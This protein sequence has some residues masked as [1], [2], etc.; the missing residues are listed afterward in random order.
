MRWQNYQLDNIVLKATEDMTLWQSEIGTIKI[1]KNTLALQIRLDDQKGGYLFCGSGKL[2][3]DTIVETEEG[4]FGRPV[5]KEI[6]KPFLMLGETEKIQWNLTE[7]K[8]GDSAETVVENQQ[9]LLAKAEDFCERF[10]RKRKYHSH[11]CCDIDGG[12]IFAFSNEADKFDL[13]L[14]KDSK[15]IY[16][17]TDMVFV[18]N[19]DKVILKSPNEVVCADDR[20]IVIKKGN[21]F[22][23]KK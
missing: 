19:D 16:K 4:A 11:D 21:S 23:I 7:T 8:E 5:D 14:T 10:F 18:S 15:L 3:L 2:V 12:L 22:I 17:A 9:E 6:D 13:L 20:K 1:D